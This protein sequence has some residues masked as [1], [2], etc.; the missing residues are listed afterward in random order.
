VKPLRLL[1]FLPIA[2]F[3]ACSNT[4][5][6]Y[7]YG[8][9]PAYR[10]LPAGFEQAEIGGTTY[11][12]NA[13]RFYKLDGEQGYLLVQPPRGHEQV[14]AASGGATPAPNGAPVA[15]APGSW[16]TAGDGKLNQTKRATNIGRSPIRRKRTVYVP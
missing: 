12:H 16:L 10:T 9:A 5:D 4:I 8:F 15:A 2:L 7:H 11:W 14:V 13:G 3:S 6:D 1:I